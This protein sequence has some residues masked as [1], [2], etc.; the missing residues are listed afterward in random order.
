MFLQTN[1][2]NNVN[3]KGLIKSVTQVLTSQPCICLSCVNLSSCKR[4]DC[5]AAAVFIQ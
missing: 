1:S 2:S 4:M 3:L 5:D